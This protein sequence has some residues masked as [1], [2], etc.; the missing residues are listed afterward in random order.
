MVAQTQ[1]L[2]I[3][4]AKTLS[5]IKSEIRKLHDVVNSI[6]DYWKEFPQYTMI[7]VLL[8]NAGHDSSTFSGYNHENE[9]K[10]LYTILE[11]L[12]KLSEYHNS[13]FENYVY[14]EVDLII[15]GNAMFEDIE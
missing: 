5:Y 2:I 3:M 10:K 8:Q 13:Y 14:T 4:K 7:S 1:K 6:A 15:S 9:V 12:R 11:V